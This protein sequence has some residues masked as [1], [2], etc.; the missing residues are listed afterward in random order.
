MFTGSSVDPPAT[1]HRR[2]GGLEIY[3]SVEHETTRGAF[4]AAQA[5]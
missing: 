3:E 4:T 2:T 1:V 5:A